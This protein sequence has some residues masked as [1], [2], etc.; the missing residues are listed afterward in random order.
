MSSIEPRQE[1][2][3]VAFYRDNLAALNKKAPFPGIEPGAVSYWQRREWRRLQRKDFEITLG[4]ANEAG[5]TLDRFWAGTDLDGLGKKLARLSRQ[6]PEAVER[7]DVSPLI[8]E[9]F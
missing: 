4:D 6:F 8:Y 9:M 1:K 7:S 2:A 5:A 3:L